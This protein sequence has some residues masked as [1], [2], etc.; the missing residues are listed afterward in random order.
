M[1]IVFL[2]GTALVMLALLAIVGSRSRALLRDPSMLPD[3][4]LAAAVDLT[5]RIMAQSRPGSPAWARAAATHKAAVDEQMRRKG[6]Q[7]FD[8]IELVP[9]PVQP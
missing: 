3:R 5:R 4:Q 6:Q 9:P 1:W 7:P 8:N 2:L